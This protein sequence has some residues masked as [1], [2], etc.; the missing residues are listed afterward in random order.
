MDLSR[1]AILAADDLKPSLEAVF[2]PE[3]DGTVHVRV[4]TGSERDAFEGYFDRSRYDNLR[5]FLLVCCVCD[6]Q[7]RGL[8]RPEDVK[9]L[10]EKSS[11]A[12]DR[13]FTAA[14]RV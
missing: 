14:M 13:V 12:L 5:A 7:G 10:G 4:M 2:I 3:W 6:G 8:F 9:A 11:A 1:E